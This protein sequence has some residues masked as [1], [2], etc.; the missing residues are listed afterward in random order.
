LNFPKIPSSPRLATPVVQLKVT[1]TIA[2]PSGSPTFSS[3][4]ETF[5]SGSRREY[6]DRSRI[7]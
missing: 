6:F 7:R 4:S 3:F 5:P 2:R 1:S